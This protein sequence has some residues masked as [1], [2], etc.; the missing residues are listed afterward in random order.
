MKFPLCS[1]AFITLFCAGLEAGELPKPARAF[2]EERCAEC[3]DADSKKGGL[4]L[5]A[6]STQLGQAPVEA[7][8]IQLFDR[9]RRGEMPPRKKEPPPPAEK[10]AFLASLGGFISDHDAARRAQNGRVLWRRLNRVEYENTLHDLLDIDIPLVDLLPQDGTAYGFDN[11][12]EGLRLSPSQIEGYLAAADASLDAAIRMGQRPK[13]LNKRFPFLEVPSVMERAFKAT[14]SLRKDGS[15]Y[16]AEYRPLADGVAIF[17]N[18][19]FGGTAIRDGY[20]EEAGLYRVRMSA[21]AIQ[22]PPGHSVVAKLM[23]ETYPTN[24]FVAAFD[25]TDQPREVELTT[26]MRRGEHFYI[27]GSGCGYARDGTHVG[28]VGAEKFTGAGMVIQWLEIEGPLLESWPPPSVRRV[29]GD[30]QVE[31]LSKP[32]RELAYRVVSERPD[33]DVERLVPAFAQRAFRRPA[34]TAETARFV[35]LARES[36]EQGGTLEAALRR[37]YK[38]ILVSPEFLFLR[39]QSG[40]LD[41]YALASRLSYFLWSTAPDEELL[42]MAAEG[43]LHEPKTL[44]DQTERLLA[45]PKARAFTHHFCGQWL[46]LRGID[47]T[48]PDH[49]LYPEFDDLLKYAMVEETESFFNEMLKEDLSISN[50]I[51][52][53]FAMLNRRLAEHYGI[54]G[55]QGEQFRKVSLPAGSHRGGL[56]TQA[57]ILK[58][59]ANGTLS[60]PVIRGVWVMKRLLGYQFQPPPP[61]AGTIEPDTRGS[62]TIREQL[63]KHRRSVSCNTCHQYIDPSGFAL[64]SYDVIGGWRD[65]YRTRGKGKPVEDPETHKGR[66]YRLG[67]SVDPSGELADGRTFANI[68]DLKKLLL[69]QKEEIARNLVNN[70]VAYSTG[71]GVTFSDRAKVQEILDRT[72]PQQYGL[73]SLIHELVQSPLF[74]TK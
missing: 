53:H 10:A 16:H 9:V 11:V 8:W 64:E 29:F 14:G 18:E 38:A 25:L 55:V 69:D 43:R 71:A 17:I 58:V 57:S 56:F 41:D 6:L 54:P 45:S 46:N 34:S 44:H 28:D 39:E 66:P 31:P 47:E 40:K 62:T 59:T 67:A 2:L 19:S 50:F 60:S 1:V 49:D 15:I 65:T 63:A 37:A 33:Q 13:A 26:R 74:Q 23:G 73:R 4:D 68:D 24:R 61:D 21:Y 22:N 35:K 20:A 32:K 48:M 27:S 52:S 70:L 42:R 12:S 30:V 36:L 51:D 7:K 3:H 5:D 72:Q